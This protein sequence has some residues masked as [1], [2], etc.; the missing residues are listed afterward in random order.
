MNFLIHLHSGWR[1]IVLVALIYAVINSFLNKSNDWKAAGKTPALLA[2]IAVHVQF[3]IGLI[4]FFIS[5]KV[6]FSGEAMKVSAL[7]FYL[8]EH[9]FLMLAAVILITIG[10]SKAKRKEDDYAKFRSIRIFFLIGLFLILL[11]IPWP[12][13][14]VGGSWY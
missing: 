4:L 2:L 7:R 3:L 11:G 12:W 8:V 14:E 10:Y 6:V 5:D 1:W 9:S 13:M